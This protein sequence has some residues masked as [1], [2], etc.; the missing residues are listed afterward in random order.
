[1]CY[2]FLRKG[3]E[4]VLM[5]ETVHCVHQYTFL[6]KL[7]HPLHSFI[8][9]N[10]TA[11]KRMLSTESMQACVHALPLFPVA[12]TGVGQNN[13]NATNTVYISLLIWCW[14]TCFNTAAVL[15]MDSYGSW[16]VPSR[17][18]YHSWRTSSSCSRDV[19]EW[20]S[21]PH[22][23]LQNW[24]GWQWCSYLMFMLGREVEVHL[25]A[26]QTMNKQL[27]LDE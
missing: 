7:Q 21:V 1:M 27:Q 10:H 14:T 8:C 4:C 9:N 25:H 11:G 12:D 17:I 6:Q 24:P 19:G 13:G 3:K 5:T 15:G 18:L 22:S 26:L 20:G 16:A 23:S 2:K